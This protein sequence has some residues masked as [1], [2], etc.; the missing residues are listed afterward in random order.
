MDV[1]AELELSPLPATLS[2]SHPT[3]SGIVLAA[4]MW[5]RIKQEVLNKSTRLA[6]QLPM[7]R[8]SWC[9]ALWG[10]GG[11]CFSCAHETQGSCSI[12]DTAHG[13]PR[14]W[15]L[16]LS[17]SIVVTFLNRKKLKY[18]DVSELGAGLLLRE[19]GGLLTQDNRIHLM[20]IYYVLG[21]GL[22]ASLVAK[23]LESSP[24][25]ETDDFCPFHSRTN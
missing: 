2:G 16:P 3:T 5:R 6:S 15:S 23:Q 22:R 14:L 4:E 18:W 19:R 17:P 21:C 7:E 25:S 20:S 12:S 10:P 13:S 11:G 9:L 24:W 8:L 1:P